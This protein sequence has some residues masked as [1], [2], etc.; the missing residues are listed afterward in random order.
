MYTRKFKRIFNVK[1]LNKLRKKSQRGI[2]PIIAT[3]LILAL[4]VAGVVIGFVQIIPYIER[5]KVETDASSIQSTLIKMDNVIWGMIS[6]SAGSYIPDSVPSRKLQ[7]TIPIGSL[8]TLSNTNNV[9]Y[10]PYPCPSPTSCPTSFDA[11]AVSQS[12][13]VISHTFSSSYTLLPENTLEYLTGSNPYQL[14]EP[15]SYTSISSSISDDYSATNISMYRLGYNHFIDLSYRPKII[16]SQTIE[17][18]QPVYNVNVFLIKLTGSTSFIGT[19]NVFLKYAGSTVEHTN[20]VGS[21]GSSFELLMSVGSS[22]NSPTAYAQFNAAPGGFTTLYRLT[23]T[24]H[25]FSLSA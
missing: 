3:I 10:Q 12:L 8:D 14:R 7:V 2:T 20:L 9:T 5:S 17:N 16:V 13:G 19:T 22:T 4:V 1:T 15:V 23:V 6:D 11:S 18:G 25:T 24:T 21:S